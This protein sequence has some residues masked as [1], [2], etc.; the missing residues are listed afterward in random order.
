MPIIIARRNQRGTDYNFTV[1]RDRVYNSLRYKIE[2]DK[3]YSDVIIDNNALND[4]PRNTDE[5]VFSR[6][7]TVQM[8]F[9]SDTNEVTYVGPILEIDEGNTIEH[10]ISMA[11]KPPNAQREMELIQ[12]WVN[13]PDAKPTEL[14]DWPGIGV[15]PINEYVTSGLLDMAFPTLFLDGRCDW[16]EPRMR[17]VH[18]HEIF[19]HLL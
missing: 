13:N 8:E 12:M 2:H 1:N 4:L 10:T 11:S 7:T 14:I 3:F 9:E 15:S 17:H 16:L 6:L 18:L 5:N 19:R